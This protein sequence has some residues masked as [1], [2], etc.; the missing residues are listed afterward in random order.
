MIKAVKSVRR[1]PDS[2][3]QKDH[4]TSPG[5]V[6]VQEKSAKGSISAIQAFE[7]PDDETP[8]EGKGE[9]GGKSAGAKKPTTAE[10]NDPY[11]SNPISKA[12]SRDNLSGPAGGGGGMTVSPLALPGPGMHLFLLLF[13]CCTASCQYT[14][15]QPII[16]TCPINKPAHHTFHRTCST[17][18]LNHSYVYTFSTHLINPPNQHP[19]SIR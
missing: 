8:R 2:A 13:L 16:S 10:G 7:A 15:C 17:H 5:P 18:L 3:S 12:N 19:L 4:S 9:G 11:R 1:N 14:P 6:V